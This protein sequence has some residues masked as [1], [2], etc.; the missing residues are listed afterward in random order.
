MANDKNVILEPKKAITAQD[1]ADIPYLLEVRKAVSWWEKQLP[2]FSGRDA[3]IA[4]QTIIDLNK[5]QYAIK[6]FFKPPVQLQGLGFGKTQHCIPLNSEEYYNAET[7]TFHTSGASLCDPKVCAAV[8]NNYSKLKEDSWGVFE[9][10]TCF[11]ME[12]FDRVADTALADYPIY[13]KIVELKVDGLSNADIQAEINSTF[14]VEYSMQWISSIWTTRVPKL[15]ASAAQDEYLNWLYLNKRH[16]TYKTCSRCKQVKLALP[17]YFNRNPSAA[18][19]YYSQ[20]KECRRK[21][22]QGKV[23]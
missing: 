16:G 18:D 2:H 14:G 8:L 6:N 4:K 11:F 20:C 5:D 3:Y 12:D 9:G 19:G 1:L 23:H 7:H 22:R 21:A 15:I 13:E 10:E 17:K